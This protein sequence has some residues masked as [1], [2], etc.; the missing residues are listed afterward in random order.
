M[1]L[2][3]AQVDGFLA[4]PDPRIATVLLH[5]PDTG[6]VA[7]RARRLAAG[8][9]DDLKDPFRVSELTGDEL[10]EKPGRLVEE[11]QALCLLGGRRLVRVRE[12]A[13]PL[14]DQPA[15]G[16]MEEDGGDTRIGPGEEAVDLRRLEL[17]AAWF[18]K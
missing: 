14:G 4:R 2:K 16:A 11:A 18:A 5:G 15:V 7:E 9:V 3:P 1:K 12:A 8:I 13:R 10:R 6:L 17:H